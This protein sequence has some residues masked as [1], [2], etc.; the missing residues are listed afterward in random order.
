M[1]KALCGGRERRFVVVAA[2]FLFLVL[3]LLIVVVVVVVTVAANATTRCSFTSARTRF[4]RAYASKVVHAVTG[5]RALRGRIY[6][7]LRLYVNPPSAHA[8]RR[9]YPREY[10]REMGLTFLEEMAS[11]P[12]VVERVACVAAA[13]QDALCTTP[14]DVPNKESRLRILYVGCRT[15]SSVSPASSLPLLH[16]IFPASH[17]AHAHT[18]RI[19]FPGYTFV[20]IMT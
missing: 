4:A 5:E 16:A 7:N 18:V 1:H 13:T 10:E 17:I 12:A 2:V 14:R 15:R 19:N 11:R 9:R 20:I 6:Q 8:R 3:L